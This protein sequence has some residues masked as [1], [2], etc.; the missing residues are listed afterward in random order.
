MAFTRR[1]GKSFVNWIGKLFSVGS[2]GKIPNPCVEVHFDH[3]EIYVISGTH[4][5]GR[6]AEKKLRDTTL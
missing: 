5:Y 6:V 4:S 1:L 2:S 3:N